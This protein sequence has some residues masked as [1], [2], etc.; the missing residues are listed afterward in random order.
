MNK[1]GFCRDRSCKDHISTLNSIIQNR[2]ENFVT[3]I[4]LQKAFDTVDHDL[5]KLSLLCNG[6]EGDFYNAIKSIYKNITSCVRIDNLLTEWFTCSAGVRQGDNLSPTMFALFIYDLAKEVKTLN[7]GIQIEDT[8]ISLL[9]YADDIAI[10][11][12]CAEHMKQI[13]DTVSWWCTKWR[14]L[15]NMKKSAVLHFRKK[16][17]RSDFMLKLNKNI[18]QYSEEYKYLGLIFQEK[19][20]FHKNARYSFE[21]WWTCTGRDDLKFSFLQ[22]NRD[23]D[24]SKI[25]LKLRSSGFGLL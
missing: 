15:I 14:L 16:G 10:I 22:G 18:L 13:L 3:F 7:K 9:L 1:I 23:L 20:N 24:L 21:S 19:I 6:I 5:L 8:N 11:S 17:H 12:D 2:K 25:I 4:D